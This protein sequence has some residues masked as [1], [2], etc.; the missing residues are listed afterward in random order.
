MDVEQQPIVVFGG[1]NFSN[2]APNL[3]PVGADVIAEREE[4]EQIEQLLLLGNQSFQQNDFHT[5]IKFYSEAL[6]IESTNANLLIARCN[7]YIQNNQIEKALEDAN[8]LL[9]SRFSN[10]KSV[11]SEARYLIVCAHK[12]SKHYSLA[13]EASLELYLQD[14]SFRNIENLVYE[15]CDDV[16]NDSTIKDDMK[17]LEFSFGLVKYAQMMLERKLLSQAQRIIECL[18]FQEAQL[19]PEVLTKAL[20]VGARILSAQKSTERAIA[21]YHECVL[22]AWRLQLLDVEA[23][24][25]L[26]LSHV[27]YGLKDYFQ[28]AFSFEKCLSVIELIES[29]K[30][31]IEILGWSVSDLIRHK[32]NILCCISES[33]LN[34]NE[35]SLALKHANEINNIVSLVDFD[36][37]RENKSNWLKVAESRQNEILAKAWERKKN[38][39]QA[40]ECAEKFLSLERE[41]NEKLY[42]ALLLCGK[43][44][45][46]MKHPCEAQKIFSEVLNKCLDDNQKEAVL[47][48]KSTEVLCLA[49]YNLG[50]L[51]LEAS[52]FEKAVKHFEDCVKQSKKVGDDRNLECKT[53][54][55]LARAHCALKQHAQAVY[56]LECGLALQKET[57]TDLNI[58]CLA[59]MALVIQYVGTYSELERARASLEDLIP[60][61]H[62][63]ALKQFI[64]DGHFLGKKTK[65]LEDVSNAYVN[66]LVKLGHIQ[67]AL[68]ASET[69]RRFKFVA[70]FAHRSELIG[71]KCEKFRNR[72]GLPV[73]IDKIMDVPKARG[74]PTFYFH[75]S[76]QNLF[77]WLISVKK[78]MQYFHKHTID[79]SENSVHSLLNSFREAFGS[80]NSGLYGFENRIIL[81]S[82]SKF[83]VFPHHKDA[84]KCNEVEQELTKQLHFAIWEPL[85]SE[86][87]K[88]SKHKTFAF[89]ISGNA[90][91][92][93]FVDIF[94]EYWKRNVIEVCPTVEV[95]ENIEMMSWLQF[96]KFDHIYTPKQNPGTAGV[97]NPYGLPSALDNVRPG[98]NDPKA[99]SGTADILGWSTLPGGGTQKNETRSALKEV[100]SLQYQ[101]Q[102]RSAGGDT[103]DMGSLYKGVNT[104]LDRIS[105]EQG[106]ALAHGFENESLR[107]DAS[108]FKK[109][110]SNSSAKGYV[111]VTQKSL[112]SKKSK[113]EMK[114]THSE[115]PDTQQ[116]DQ[117]SVSGLSTELGS[118]ENHVKVR[119][120]L[121]DSFSTLISS[122]WNDKHV[123][124]SKVAI[125]NYNPA[126]FNR[127]F[128]FIGA[129]ILPS[130]VTFLDFL[131]KPLKCLTSA[132]EELKTC[133]GYFKSSALMGEQCTKN[134]ALYSLERC[135]CVHLATYVNYETAHIAFTPNELHQ[136]LNNVS[137][138]TCC[139]SMQDLLDIDLAGIELFVLSAFPSQKHS[140]V[141]SF[142]NLPTLLLALGVKCVVY[143]CQAVSS[144]AMAKFYHYFY[145]ALRKIEP[146]CKVS[147]ALVYAK[148]HMKKDSTF[149]SPENWKSFQ[150]MGLDIEINGKEMIHEMLDEVINKVEKSYAVDPLNVECGEAVVPPSH[151]ILSELRK[152]VAD[153]IMDNMN[154]LSILDPLFNLTLL[155]VDQCCGSN[156]KPD[157]LHRI[158]DPRLVKTQSVLI[159]LQFMRFDFQ[160]YGC[161]DRLEDLDHPVV[162]WPHWDK[163]GLLRPALEVFRNLILLKD[164][165]LAL[166]EMVA[167]L[168]M[169]LKN[170]NASIIGAKMSF[171]DA[172]S[173]MSESLDGEVAETVDMISLLIDVLSLSEH[174]PQVQL[175][176][177]DSGVRKVWNCSPCRRLLAAIGFHQVDLALMSYRNLANARYQQSVLRI[178][179]ALS[180]KFALGRKVSFSDF[181]QSF[182]KTRR[183][184]SSGIFSA[185]NCSTTT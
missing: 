167:V 108:S 35:I 123:R 1:T 173:G 42:E 111:A 145:R 36:D 85:K 158:Q 32:I 74:V 139:T 69:A 66:I 4:I 51:E 39:V 53:Y 157:L 92:V 46:K 118:A 38:Y 182:F 10:E 161:T 77:V 177:T 143:S 75:I 19:S 40:S 150:M 171:S 120:K 16:L 127:I 31:I 57:S 25:R 176:I 80:R 179:C 132:Q 59:E 170:E 137:S 102:I 149:A 134:E 162:V 23:E 140:N 116:S 122:T 43:L 113:P 83:R 88:I 79:N 142:W 154:D 181:T 97:H 136:K 109:P 71:G 148:E 2:V 13:L 156:L 81:D 117:M 8:H 87:K 11:Q 17:Q 146:V 9:G 63:S 33:F 119:A 104:N 24:A 155:A 49:L 60:R 106:Y 95:F 115:S 159:L 152:L 184:L 169:T 185:P 14:N 121:E 90:G 3:A 50:K 124:T 20:L 128:R 174:A 6:E 125:E 54:V 44:Q 62:E 15:A 37:E 153:L 5:A 107:T 18:V 103:V 180:G 29:K 165:T 131:W 89:I 78:G 99:I 135:C 56:S 26:E 183:P 114:V 47:R 130:K 67:S 68:I 73:E 82:A 175:M 178:L 138:E 101:R 27:Y 72:L 112:L 30:S 22:R 144:K 126:G 86:L 58:A 100:P 41:I 141:S 163:N 84:M 98:V 164:N 7:A 96:L 64:R 70:M 61:F 147:E 160:P 21:T 166:E 151:R 55:L 172:N 45:R 105:S 168:R 93:P 91:V 76:E 94:A 12:S 48:R 65:L 52:N 110:Q 129:P 34:L 133:S 28:A